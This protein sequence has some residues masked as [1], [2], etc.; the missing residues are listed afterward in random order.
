MLFCAVTLVLVP[1]VSERLAGPLAAVAVLLAGGARFR[2][3]TRG[4]DGLFVMAETES[5]TGST[6]FSRK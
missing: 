4:R 6:P 3:R 2:A 1:E 5:K